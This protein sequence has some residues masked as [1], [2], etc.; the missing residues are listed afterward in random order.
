[1]L[2]TEITAAL[3]QK[4]DRMLRVGM[5]METIATAVGITPYVAEIIARYQNRKVRNRVAPRGPTR[6]QRP[7]GDRCHDDPL[8]PTHARCWDASLLGDCPRGGCIG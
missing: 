7:E 3:V 6:G 1:M 2:R 8:H 5:D 4:I